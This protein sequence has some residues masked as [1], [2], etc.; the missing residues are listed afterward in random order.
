MEITLVTAR[1]TAPLIIV[2]GGA[3]AYLKTTTDAQR[4]RRGERLA[5]VACLG[6]A[7]V[8]SG[9]ARAGVLAA[10]AAME[11]DPDFNAGYG[12]KLQRDG[13]P[14]V[15]AGLA[16]GGSQRVTSVFNVEGCL[17]P[18]ELADALQTKGDRNLDGQ[19]G[20]RLM[21]E[22]G[23]APTELRTQKTT[24]RWRSLL[25]SGELA[26]PEAAIGDT[27]EPELDAA[28]AAG[29]PVPEDLRPDERYGTVGAVAVD[30]DGQV[31]AC[32]STGGR[33]HE[34][35]GRLTDSG[36]P[37]GNYAVP[38]CGVSATGFGEQIIDLDV[39]G[40]ICVRALDGHPLPEAL[41]R[42]FEEVRA[43]GG[44]LGAIAAHTDGTV[45][46]A[47][48]T[49]ACG[50]AWADGSGAQHVDQHGRAPTDHPEEP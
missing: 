34:V 24:A 11:E 19:G 25:E 40:R 14:R 30:A 5:E 50:V 31:W 39:A 49:E 15:S 23:I 35:V 43:H 44:L 12:S 27:G 37:A 13:V 17:H 48:S 21:L 26:D 33:G 29:V 1:L 7:A 41:R 28:R 36:M 20:A 22:L 8:E 4:L 42:T 9:G 47:H 10:V 38:C 3:G 6:L 16:D 32:T 2:H 45:G 46:Y 18:S